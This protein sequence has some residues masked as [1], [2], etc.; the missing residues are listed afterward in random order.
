MI[1][2]PFLNWYFEEVFR[3]APKFDKNA[4][5]IFELSQAGRR[6]KRRMR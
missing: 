3:E 1:L 6:V 4:W 5:N 2:C